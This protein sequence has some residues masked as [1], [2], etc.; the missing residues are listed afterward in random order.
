MLEAKECIV[1]KRILLS[2]LTLPVQ[3]TFFTITEHFMMPCP[4]RPFFF[5]YKLSMTLK[6]HQ[7]EKV[8]SALAAV[9]L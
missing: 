1:F 6:L 2:L 4:V 8:N 7:N 3:C 5:I 9:R